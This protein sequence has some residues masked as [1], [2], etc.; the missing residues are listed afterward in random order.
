MVEPQQHAPLV[1][2]H[3]G[4]PWGCFLQNAFSVKSL[5]WNRVEKQ[6]DASSSQ[7]SRTRTGKQIEPWSLE[8]VIAVFIARCKAHTFYLMAFHRFHRYLV[9]LEVFLTNIDKSHP[10]A[11]ELLMK[12]GIAVV[13]SLIPGVLS[14]VD[15]TVDETFTKLP[16]SAGS[17]ILY[18]LIWC[19]E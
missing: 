11:K 15:K 2:Y 16:K 18:L 1:N 6:S 12:G 14:A 19:L 10:G 7:C 13:R 8:L 9:W 17:K 5:N 4:L 3:P